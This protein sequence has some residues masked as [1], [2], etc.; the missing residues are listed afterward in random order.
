[1]PQILNPEI[2]EEKDLCLYDKKKLLKDAKLIYKKDDV[3][4][5]WKCADEHR[6]IDE[7]YFFLILKT[8]LITVVEFWFHEFGNIQIPKIKNTTTL[9][10]HR[11]CGFATLIYTQMFEK[12]GGLMSDVTLNGLKKKPNGSYKLWLNLINK[13]NHS[14]YDEKEQKIISY[15]KY[16]AF[17]SE[18]KSYRRIL[19]FQDKYSIYFKNNC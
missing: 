10:K 4:I 5:Y 9:K 12:F 18:R 1:M 15:S 8:K 19:I 16:V 17:E 6:I 13:N 14:I 3:K 7:D 2:F 11:G